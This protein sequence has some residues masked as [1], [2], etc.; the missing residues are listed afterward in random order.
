MGSETQTV[1]ICAFAIGDL[2]I[3][4]SPNEMD[5]RLGMYVKENSPYTMTFMSAYSNGNY[6]YIPAESSFPNAGYEVNSCRYVAGT[7]EIMANEI[8]ELLKTV[9]QN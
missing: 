6:G 8:V 4:T 9:H 7:G 2:A 3:A 5:H 1:S